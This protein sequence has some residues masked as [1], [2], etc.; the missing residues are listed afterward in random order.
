MLMADKLDVDTV[1]EGVETFEQVKFLREIGA[2][3][4]QGFYWGKPN[5][6]LSK[7]S[8]FENLKFVALNPVTNA[9]AIEIVIPSV[10]S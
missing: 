3:K 8:V 6:L 9:V 1:V 7:H 5:D 10:T 4:M 2:D